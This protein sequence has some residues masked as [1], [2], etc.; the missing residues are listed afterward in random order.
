[1]GFLLTL[2]SIQLVPMMT[3]LVGWRWTFA[4]LTI[5]PAVGTWGMWMLKRSPEAICLAGGRR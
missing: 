5:G 2:A 1:M 4:F 3:D